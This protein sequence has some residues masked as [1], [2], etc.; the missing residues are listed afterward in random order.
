MEVV[1][2]NAFGF[3]PPKQHL[4]T[5]AKFP[6][7]VKMENTDKAK[8]PSTPEYLAQLLK[9]RKSLEYVPNVFIHTERLL[10]EEISRVRTSLYSLDIQ[11][12]PLQLPEE[13]GPKVQK[14]DKI[15]VP[16]KAYPDFNFVGR[17][18]G[19]RGMTA[20][21]LEKETGCKI[22]VRGKGSMR[23]KA[24]EAQN[25]GKTNW[26]H[27]SEELHVLITV[28]DTEERAN[29]KLQRAAEE[30]KKLLVPTAD[31][32]DELK[33]KQLMEL[34]LLNGTYRE[35]NVA[36]AQ[37]AFTA[38]PLA[39]TQVVRQMP[40]PSQPPCSTTPSPLVS[41]RTVPP[42]G[43][44]LVP[45]PLR[46]PTPAAQA[47]L[48]ATPFLPRV[49]SQSILASGLNGFNHA[50]GHTMLPAQD[51]SGSI[52]YHIDPYQMGLTPA[53]LDYQGT[54]GSHDGAIG[55]LKTCFMSKPQV[56][57]IPKLLSQFGRCDIFD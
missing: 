29:I 31:G 35:P 44:A 37:T 52:I 23:D 1:N 28:E 20:K 21:Q 53:L 41:P 50:V 26:E 9:D 24:K 47:H 27:L 56:C 33:K 49:S 40:A 17:I 46:S 11:K 16:V 12:K 4:T 54:P 38:A 5:F 45:Q 2:M 22:M 34:A 3:N 6:N 13:R 8:M 57:Q 36:K 10:D 55:R 48:M 32:E 51:A 7:A 30:I 14:Q 42:P 18:L 25:I 15:F 39:T 43:P 19:P